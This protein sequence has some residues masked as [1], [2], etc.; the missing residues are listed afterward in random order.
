MLILVNY[1]HSLFLFFVRYKFH[2]DSLILGDALINGYYN[3]YKEPAISEG[4]T[5][6]I[7]VNIIPDFKYEQ[8]HSLY[9]M[10]LVEK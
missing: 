10:Y 6:V 5:E 2:C 4:F 7:K 3:K 8:H 1:L 9:H